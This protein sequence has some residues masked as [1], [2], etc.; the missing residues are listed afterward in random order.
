MSELR[1]IELPFLGGPSGTSREPERPDPEEAKLEDVD[2]HLQ[3]TRDLVDLLEHHFRG[4]PR[5][6]VRSGVTLYYEEGNPAASFVPDLFV[7]RDGG[8]RPRPGYLELWR[9]G[10]SPAAVIEVTAA[11]TR[12]EDL[13]VKRDVCERFGVEEYFLYDPLGEYLDPPLR[14]YRLAAGKYRPLAPRADG[15][16][17]SRL[18]LA[19]DAGGGRLT[20]VDVETG[21]PLMHT[22]EA[23]DELERLRSDVIRMLGE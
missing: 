15:A 19:F 16:V 22:T 23:L 12:D 7:V 8:E 17:V 21:N 14:G 3:E 1:S 4:D 10:V 20:V 11:A 13:G 18:G 5:V 9:K 2:V 6:H